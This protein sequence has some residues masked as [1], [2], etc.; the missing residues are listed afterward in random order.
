MNYADTIRYSERS[1]NK[2][3]FYCVKQKPSYTGSTGEGV[4]DLLFSIPL[5]KHCNVLARQWLRSSK[6]SSHGVRIRI[7]AIKMA[8]S[9]T[10]WKFKVAMVSQPDEMHSWLSKR[11]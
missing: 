2:G 9:C 10:P 3:A 7:Q 8:I 1:H 6:E 5:F 4:Q 11:L